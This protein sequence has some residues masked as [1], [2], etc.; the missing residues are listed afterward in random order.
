LETD[1]SLY[2]AY[3][4]GCDDALIELLRRHREGMMIFIYEIVGNMDDAE[5]LM[6]DSFAVLLSREK[7]FS[8]RSSFKTWL[9]SIGRNKAVSFLRRQHCHEEKYADLFTDSAGMSADFTVLKE[10]QSRELITAMNSLKKEYRSALYLT[11][12]EEMT[13]EETGRVMKKTKKQVSDLIYNAK[14][15]LRDTLEKEGFSYENT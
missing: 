13:I 7:A 6:M 11:Y 2:R 8:G 1:E 3:L 9:F 10:E 15:S 5:N 4:H 12:F 14:K